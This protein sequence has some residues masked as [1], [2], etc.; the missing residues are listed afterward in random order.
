MKENIYRTHMCGCITESEI[1]RSVRVSGWVSS[2]RDHG[3]VI[4]IDLRDET[5]IVQVVTEETEDML[6]ITRESVITVSGTVRARRSEDV[7]TN[8]KTGKVEVVIS[9]L[10]VLSKSTNILPFE[11][12][13]SRN[14]SDEVRLKY[15]YLDLRNPKVHNQILLRTEIIDYL[16]SIL[17]SEGFHEIQ[18][19]ILT[20]TSP[21]GAR[22]F[23]VPSRKFKGKFYALPQSPQ[24]F[25]QLLMISG[26]NKYFQI[27]P[28]FRD[29]D[30]RSDR[31][32]GDFY[33]L[34]IE[35]SFVTIEE[36]YDLAEM[37][38]TKTFAKFSDRPMTKA[39]FPRIPYDESMLKY[40]I[41]RPDLR[42]PLVIQ[43]LTHIFESTAFVPFRKCVVRGIKVENISDYATSIG[44]PGIGYIK[45]NSDLSFNGPIDKYLTEEERSSLI[46]E[47]DLKSGDVLFFIAD[48][49][50]YNKYAGQIRT[51][52]GEKLD[53]IDED[54]LEFCIITDFP[55]YS[56]N[57]DLNKVDF[58]HNPFSM[59]KGGMEA[60][61]KVDLLDIKCMQF[62][63]VCNGY[64]MLSG[65]IR[66]HDKELL[67]K[68]FEKV[69]YTEE[70][71]K[72]RFTSLYTAFN[73][74]VPPHGG[75][76]PGIDKIIMLVSREDNIRNVVA[77]P[78]T[79]GGQDLMMGAPSEAEE[80]QLREVHINIRK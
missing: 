80:T 44:M 33:Q 74:G 27:A 66:N 6:K 17:K 79:A 67:V 9:S 28:C 55:M 31:L 46:S 71:I 47:C 26:F 75:I 37:I 48:K 68:A 38:F 11:I 57:E 3:G 51:Y 35:E 32:Y 2:I 63:F 18:T 53:L 42:N 61:E 36:L 24:I 20:A 5:G 56:Y 64:E 54:K 70:T 49:V 7:N 78:M 8:L 25:K 73:Y 16:R 12:D 21:E 41:D 77:F 13:E 50:N 45:I 60:L 43:D 59:I 1:Q 52:L 69:G 29:E 14:S 34:D 58:T 10:E 4:F 22:D 19:P 40:G 72:T 23:I 62:D 76:G 15:R 30:A 39:P 65:A